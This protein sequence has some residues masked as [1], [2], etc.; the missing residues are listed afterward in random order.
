VIG[1]LP[2]AA[3]GCGTLRDTI[4]AGKVGAAAPAGQD[5]DIGGKR[6]LVRYSAEEPGFSCRK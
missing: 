4:A 6:L 3:A 1:V 2:F 5:L